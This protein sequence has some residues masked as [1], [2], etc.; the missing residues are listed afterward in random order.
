M[1]LGNCQPVGGGECLEPSVEDRGPVR[2]E[3]WGTREGFL[4]FDLIL[5]GM[6]VGVGRPGGHNPGG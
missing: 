3:T 4:W 6:C 5:G 1:E 2:K